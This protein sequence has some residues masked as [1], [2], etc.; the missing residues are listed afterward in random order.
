MEILWVRGIPNPSATQKTTKSQRVSKGQSLNTSL[1]AGSVRGV[2]K[3]PRIQCIPEVGPRLKTKLLRNQP[4][5]L[6]LKGRNNRFKLMSN[7]NKEYSLLSSFLQWWCIHRKV[8]V[9]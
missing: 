4:P 1:G 2:S 5:S 8:R 7:L 6:M 3:I 9:L